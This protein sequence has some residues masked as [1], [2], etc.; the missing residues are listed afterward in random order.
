MLDHELHHPVLICRCAQYL[1][2]VH[3]R[4]GPLDE[5]RLTRF[6]NH[7]KRLCLRQNHISF[8]DP[9]VFH[10]LVKLEELDFYDN[11]I[12]DPGNALDN[13]SNLTY[14]FSPDEN[15]MQWLDDSQPP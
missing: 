13:L 3:S 10:L 9:E 6:A 2:L 5:L 12:K 14:V 15:P 1:E 4:I 8:L 7:L 11:K